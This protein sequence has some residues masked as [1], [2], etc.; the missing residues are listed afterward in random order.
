MNFPACVNA[1]WDGSSTQSFN[2]SS[3]P[4]YDE[5]SEVGKPHKSSSSGGSLKEKH[6]P[7]SYKSSVRTVALCVGAF[8]PFSLCWSYG[9]YTL[10]L[11]C[12]QCLY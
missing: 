6:G 2:G 8:W 7:E 3:T 10:M 9:S 11:K 1:E 12:S 5:S 4:S